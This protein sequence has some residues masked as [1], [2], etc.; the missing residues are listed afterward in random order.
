M[1]WEEKKHVF[2]KIPLKIC[3]GIGMSLRNL[4]YDLSKKSIMEASSMA[5]FNSDINIKIK[6]IPRG[7]L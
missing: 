4:S 5:A 7:E 1:T 3:Y 6:F 2:F